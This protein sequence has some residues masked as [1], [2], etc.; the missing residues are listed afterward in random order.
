[1]A[2]LG[3]V[4]ID[5]RPIDASAATISVFDNAVL[6]G[7]GCFESLRSYRGVA[8]RQREHLDRLERSAAALGI[9]LPSRADMDRWVADRAAEG[10]CSVKVVA[11]GGCDGGG[12]PPRF[13]VFAEPLPVVDETLTLLPVDAPWHPDGAVS[14][15][16]G[17]KT[18]SYGP[19]MA[20]RR[21][22]RTAGFGDALLIGRSGRVLEGPTNSVAWVTGGIL[23]TPGLDL[24]ILASITRAAV[25]DVA[26]AE[27]IEVRE[28]HFG[29][30]RV[31][32]ADEVVAL[33]TFREVQPV[34]RVGATTIDVG[35]VTA[36]LRAGFRALV[37]RETEPRR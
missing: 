4:L 18:L 15:L 28:G 17:A 21:R 36:K 33:S 8:F 2:A 37:D 27:G 32:T 6:R 12:D 22:A 10:E 30:E 25:I 5:G 11:T 23:E 7:V 9:G 34:V 16:T 29:L 24:G 31:R 1:M 13:I 20:A 3:H 19:N 14:E 26:R 35:P